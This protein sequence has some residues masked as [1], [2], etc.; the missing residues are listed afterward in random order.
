MSEVID[1]I[2]KFL[3]HKL[4][5]NSGNEQFW[6]REQDTVYGD[7]VYPVRSSRLALVS[8]DNV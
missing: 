2:D 1:V 4:K 6:H 3:K 8:T 5:M 7:A